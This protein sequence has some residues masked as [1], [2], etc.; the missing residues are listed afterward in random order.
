[1]AATQSA[2]QQGADEAAKAAEEKAKADAAAAEKAKADA[3]KPA[4]APVVVLGAAVV[5]RTS[6]G[7]ERYLY[8]GATVD[9]GSFDKDSVKHAT[10]IGLIGKK[11]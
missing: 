1:M 8:R 7:S 10:S 6:D 4:T 5:L 2:P 9:T 3:A 11:K